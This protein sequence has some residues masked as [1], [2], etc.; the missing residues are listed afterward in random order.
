MNSSDKYDSRMFK[1]MRKEQKYQL[2]KYLIHLKYL[3]KYDLA[4]YANTKPSC[5]HGSLRVIFHLSRGESGGT[6]IAVLGVLL[7]QFSYGAQCLK[8]HRLT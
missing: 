6:A 3:E 8:I 2:K 4:V 7:L 1:G 5:A